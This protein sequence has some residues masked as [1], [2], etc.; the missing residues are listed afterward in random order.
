MLVEQVI[1]CKTVK[2]TNLVVHKLGS[3][4]W[5]NIVGAYF[6]ECGDDL[7]AGFHGVMLRKIGFPK[8]DKSLAMLVTPI[9]YCLT[10][11]LT[12]CLEGCPT[13]YNKLWDSHNQPMISV[14]LERP[15]RVFARWIKVIFQAL[16]LR[17]KEEFKIWK[18]PVSLCVSG[19][20]PLFGR[21]RPIWSTNCET[22][23]NNQAD[24]RVQ[25]IKRN[26]R[27]GAFRQI[28]MILDRKLKIKTQ[29]DSRTFVKQF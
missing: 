6:T 24:E 16:L 14:N 11:C 20:E 4:C 18:L 29:N 26:F 9:G 25:N 17:S 8:L 7:A 5:L 13:N 19:E 12:V 27:L 3:Q 10:G 23:H 28:Q 2:P 22:P 21:R 1:V 15:S